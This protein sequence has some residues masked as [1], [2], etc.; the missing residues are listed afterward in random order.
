MNKRSAKVLDQE[1]YYFKGVEY[2]SDGVL[3]DQLLE[4][5]PF[6]RAEEGYM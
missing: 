2:D 5:C 1:E 3:V 4:A 6:V